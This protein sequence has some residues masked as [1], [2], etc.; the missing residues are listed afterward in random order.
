MCRFIYGILKKKLDQ[1]YEK[2][3]PDLNIMFVYNM[4]FRAMSKM[5][6]GMVS[7]EMAEGFV[8]VANG[9]FFRGMGRVIGGFFRNQR[10]NKKYE[11]E[12]RKAR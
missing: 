11:A 2:G 9:H 1:S 10:A 5:S 7:R 12:L 6:G 4:P 3:V 8:T